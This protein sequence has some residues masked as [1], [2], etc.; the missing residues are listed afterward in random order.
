MSGHL[1]LFSNSQRDRV[2]ILY[3]DENGLWQPV[4]KVDKFQMRRYC[5]FPKRLVPER[6]R[7][8]P[9]RDSTAPSG[10]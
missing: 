9:V 10:R 1:F 3:A 7:I 6:A 4:V 8:V 2:K 5:G